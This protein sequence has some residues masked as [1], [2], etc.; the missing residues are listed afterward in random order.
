MSVH[1]AKLRLG[2]TQKQVSPFAPRKDAAFAER[3]ATIR[4]IL[5]RRSWATAFLVLASAWLVCGTV[6]ALDHDVVIAVYQGPCRDGDFPANLS[7]VRRVV[8]EARARGC[9]FLAFPEA[10]LSGCDTFAHLKQGARRLDDAEL[11]AFIDET[12]AHEL[13][14]LVGMT[15]IEKEG[16]YNSVL[17]IEHGR[18]LGIYDKVMLLE[19]ERR[20]YGILPGKCVPV[21]K[22]HG[23][24]FAVNVCHDTS[25]PQPAMMARLQ[26][27]EILFTPHY[28]AIPTQ[29]MD[30]H[31]KWV[32]NTHIGLACQMKMVVA[33]PTSWSRRKGTAWATA[34]AS[35]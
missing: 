20:E 12:A 22:A 19:G 4:Q 24:R 25:F 10:F 15:R 30:E 14:V 18:L 23:V 11:R 16:M 34:T 6:M 32:R 8:A 21:F 5:I 13:V 3:K 29:A 26:G 33:H 2:P 17:V 1:L 9:D 31:R 7:T 27:A 28:N 35:S